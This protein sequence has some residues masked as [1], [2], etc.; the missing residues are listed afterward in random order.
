MRNDGAALVLPV[1]VKFLF[2]SQLICTEII[3]SPAMPVFFSVAVVCTPP[4]DELLIHLF[5][6]AFIN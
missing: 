6:L 3:P 4:E 5:T 1:G 2:W